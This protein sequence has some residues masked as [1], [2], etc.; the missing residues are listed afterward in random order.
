MPSM[1]NL[2]ISLNEG[3]GFHDN[4]RFLL[5]LSSVA[6]VSLFFSIIIPSEIVGCESE[7]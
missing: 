7:K 3:L 6:V 1:G 2:L 5:S 4:Q